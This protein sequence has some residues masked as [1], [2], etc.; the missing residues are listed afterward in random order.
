MV[1]DKVLL[2]LRILAYAVSFCVSSFVLFFVFFPQIHP[3]MCITVVHHSLKKCVTAV[4]WHSSLSDCPSEVQIRVHP[5][6]SWLRSGMFV[7]GV[8]PQRDLC[9]ISE[10]KHGGEGPQSDEKFFWG[11][12]GSS[13]YI[14]LD[15]KI[16]PSE[17]DV[18]QA[19]CQVSTQTFGKTYARNMLRER[20]D[21][22]CRL[23][24]LQPL[25]EMG[26]G[27]SQHLLTHHGFRRTRC[28][29]SW[30]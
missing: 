12:F 26:W 7:P 23:L 21:V 20:N 4:D 15:L 17:P 24:I 6:L 14:L 10:P 9:R 25:A 28:L 29:T 30:W 13:F 27:R 3:G 1:T 8:F 19:L 22:I 5:V 11:L 18:W 2:V 16:Q